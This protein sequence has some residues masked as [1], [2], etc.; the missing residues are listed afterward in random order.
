MSQRTPSSACR[1]YQQPPHRP[2]GGFDDSHVDDWLIV[3]GGGGYVDG[4]V[5]DYYCCCPLQNFD[6]YDDERRVIQRNFQ[7]K[8]YYYDYNYIN[9]NPY[10]EEDFGLLRSITQMNWLNSTHC[11]VRCGTFDPYYSATAES[12]QRQESSGKNYFVDEYKYL[13]FL[14]L[15]KYWINNKHH[16][17]RNCPPIPSHSRFVDDATRSRH[18]SQRTN[19]FCWLYSFIYTLHVFRRIRYGKIFFTKANHLIHCWFSRVSRGLSFFKKEIEWR[20]YCTNKP[21]NICL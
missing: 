13:F 16:R 7:V 18:K 3:G 17:Q 15:D 1:R 10:Y 11:S 21:K 5:T 6:D 9:A 12:S 19:E 20:R 8:M 2:H 14:G 4:V